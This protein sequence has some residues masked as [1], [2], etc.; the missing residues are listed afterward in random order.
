[1]SL[2]VVL[3]PALLQVAVGDG[4]ERLVGPVHAADNSLTLL[5]LQACGWGHHGDG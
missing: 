1:M 3:V 5:C 4:L 2:I